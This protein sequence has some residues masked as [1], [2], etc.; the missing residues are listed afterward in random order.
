M[1]LT[2]RQTDGAF[3]RQTDGWTFCSRPRPSYTAYIDAAR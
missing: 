1:R 3:D 2:D